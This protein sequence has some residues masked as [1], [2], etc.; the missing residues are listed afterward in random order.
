MSKYTAQ[1]GR[2]ESKMT[3]RTI[4]LHVIDKILTKYKI[5]IKIVS[6]VYK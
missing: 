1:P 4:K 5:L 6:A 2:A 3:Q